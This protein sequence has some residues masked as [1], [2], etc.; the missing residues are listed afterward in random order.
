MRQR[1]PEKPTEGACNSRFEPLAKTWPLDG[2]RA[3][4]EPG[5]AMNIVLL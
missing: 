4:C 2:R 3:G 1:A 5:N